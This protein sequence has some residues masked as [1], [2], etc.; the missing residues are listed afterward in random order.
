MEKDASSGSSY[1]VSTD[2]SSGVDERDAHLSTSTSDLTRELAQLLAVSIARQQADKAAGVP[3]NAGLTSLASLVS[4]VSAQRT[5][6]PVAKDGLSA[7]SYPKRTDRTAM[8]PEAGTGEASADDEPMPIPST[9]REQTY[10]DDRSYRQQ[11]GAALLGLAAGL[12]IVVPTVLWMSGWFE[13]RRS[14]PATPR[15][16]AAIE[17]KI[18]EVRTM[19]VQVHP[20]EKP[21]AAAQYVTGSVAPRAMIEAVPAVAD[22]PAASALAAKFA[23]PPPADTQAQHN[24]VIAQASR[25]LESGDVMGAREMLAAVE[26]GRQGPVLFALAETYDPNMLAAWGSR[27]V[28]ADVARARALYRK[29]LS[30]GVASAHGRLEALK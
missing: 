26:D 10:D 17:P 15:I 5:L 18:A 2:G 23:E 1:A 25:R 14:N 22:Q 21:E 28:A 4:A 9:W 12:M 24:D 16:A 30:L 11:M 7:L 27:G 6:T 20:V 29:A 3:T 13:A 8:V 19:K